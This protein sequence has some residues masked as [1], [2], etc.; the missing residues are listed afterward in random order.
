MVTY[1]S[2]DLECE[3]TCEPGSDRSCSK[4]LQGVVKAV[5]CTYPIYTMTE[6]VLD[7]QLLS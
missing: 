6:Y 4:I 2:P 7:R 5:G 3:L 1:K